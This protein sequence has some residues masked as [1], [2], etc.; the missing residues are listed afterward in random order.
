MSQ[1][2]SNQRVALVIPMLNEATTLLPL[3]RA[4]QG[5]EQQVMQA[6]LARN[7]VN[8]VKSGVT[9]PFYA[10]LSFFGFALL[11]IKNILLNE[12]GY[13]SFF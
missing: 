13:F 7:G 6:V 4:I 12:G 2:D 1:Q 5:Q 11:N 3:L 8:L 9:I 10:R